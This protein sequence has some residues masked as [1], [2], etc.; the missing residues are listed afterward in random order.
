MRLTGYSSIE[1]GQT[2]IMSSLTPSTTSDGIGE[3]LG[4]RLDDVV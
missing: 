3:G 1:V 4:M 2:L